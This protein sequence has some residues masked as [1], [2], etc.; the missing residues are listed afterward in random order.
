M[1]MRKVLLRLSLLLILLS[2]KSQATVFYVQ[3]HN[4]GLFP[5]PQFS[6]SLRECITL[7]NT[8]TPAAPDIIIDTVT[9]SSSITLVAQLPNITTSVIINGGS[10][11]NSI[12]TV[13][14][15]NAFAFNIFNIGSISGIAS[16]QYVELNRLR[17][18]NGFTVT[19]G[20]GINVQNCTLTLNNCEVVNNGNFNGLG[21]GIYAGDAI[22]TINNSTIANNTINNGAGGGL[23]FGGS[24]GSFSMLN[25]TVFGNAALSGS[26][27]GIDFNSSAPISVVSSTIVQNSAVDGGGIFINQ[28]EIMLEN[29]I[30]ANNTI[31]NTGNGADIFKSTG[32]DVMNGVNSAFGHN[33]IGNLSGFSFNPSAITAT[34]VSPT[35]VAEIVSSTLSTTNSITSYLMPTA[36]SPAI[37]AGVS[38]NPPSTDLDQRGNSVVNTRDIGAVEYPALIVADQTSC[39]PAVFTLTVSGGTSVT[40]PIYNWYNCESCST[41][42]GTGSTFVTPTISSPDSFYVAEVSACSNPKRYKVRTTVFPIPPTPTISA[43]GYAAGTDTIV[44][45]NNGPTVT[46]TSSSVSTGLYSWNTTPAQTTQSIVESAGGNYTVTITDVNNCTKASEPFTIISVAPPITPVIT[47]SIGGTGT[48]ICASDTAVLTATTSST[49]ITHYEWTINPASANVNGA[50]TLVSIDAVDEGDYTVIVYSGPACFSQSLPFTINHNPLPPKPSVI[51]GG[52]ITFCNGDS[53]VLTSSDIINTNTWNTIPVSIPVS[54]ISITVKDSGY[55]YTTVTDGN[56]CKNY[57]DTVKVTVNFPIKPT[58]TYPTTDSTTFCDGDSITITSSPSASYLWSNGA[59][60]QT[61]VVKVTTANLSVTTTDVNGCSATSDSLQITVIPITT[62]IITALGATTF[63]DGGSVTIESDQLVGN[64]WSPN[65]ETTTSISV[66]QSGSYYVTIPGCSDTSNVITVTVNPNPVTPVVTNNSS[67]TFCDGDSVLLV[68][69]SPESGLSYLWTAPTSNTNDTLIVKTSGT[70]TVTVSNAFSCSATSLPATVTVNSL[71]TKPIATLLSPSNVIC[72][73]DSVLITSNLATNNHWNNNDT[74]QVITVKTTGLYFLQTSDLNGCFSENSD[75]IFVTVNTP[76]KPV[77]T[78]DDTLTFCDGDSVHLSSSIPTNILWSNGQTTQTITIFASG[79]FYVE[80]TDPLNSCVGRSNDTIVTVLPTTQPVV[81]ALGN[82]VFCQGDSVTLSSSS[83]AGNQWYLNGNPITGEVNQTITVTASG[84]YS[85]SIPGCASQ[86][87]AVPVT[88][89]S[90]PTAPVILPLGPTTYCADKSVTL[91]SSYPNPGNVWSTSETTQSIVVTGKNTI[92]LTYT[93]A[94]GCSSTSLP[95]STDTIALPAK[96]TIT[97]STGLDVFCTGG[98]IDLTSSYASNNVWNNGNTNQTI[99]TNISGTFTVTHTDV[100]GCSSTSL[101]KVINE[102]APFTPTITLS[103]NDTICEGQ[104]LTLTS[105]EP[106]GNEW[107]TGDTTQSI[108]ISTPGNYNVLL[109]SCDLPSDSVKVTVL[110]LP[111]KPLVTALGATLF[112]QGDSSLLFSNIDGVSWSVGSV[113]GDSIY[114]KTTGDYYAINSNSFG[115][116]N[117]SDTI[118]VLVTDT[119][120]VVLNTP[121]SQCG[122]TLTFDAGYPGST[123][124]WS[125][126]ATTQQVTVNVG[127]PLSVTVTNACGS[128]TSNTIIV[129]INEVPV[130]ALGADIQQCGGTVNLDAQNPGATYF[131]S[132]NETTQSITINTTGVYSVT[133]TTAAGCSASD[134][135]SVNVDGTLPVVN[136]GNNVSQCGGTV[137]LSAANPFS[138]YQWYTTSAPSTILSTN[139]SFVVSNSGNYVAAVTNGCGT[140][141][142]TVSIAINAIPV[143]NLATSTNVCNTLATLNAQNTGSTYLWSTGETTQSITVAASGNYCVTVTTAQGCTASDCSNV[144]VS[145]IAPFVNLG[146]DG[147]YCADSLLLDAGNNGSVYTWILPNNSILNSQTIYANVSGTYV[148]L[149]NNGCGTDIDSITVNLL[150]PAQVDLGGPFETCATPVNL[151]A[152]AQPIGT[153]FSWTYNNNPIVNN[154]NSTTASV[155]GNYQVTV[156]N[157]LGCT[158]SSTAIVTIN[159]LPVAPSLT[160]PANNCGDFTINLGSYPVGTTVSWFDGTNTLVATGTSYTINASGTYYVTVANQCDTVT[161][162]SISINILPTPTTNL[163]GPQNTCNT[164][165]TLDAGVQ[166]AGS[167]FTWS[168]G[169]IVYNDSTGQTFVA[170]QT[171]A[172]TVVVTNLAGCSATSTSNVTIDLPIVPSAIAAPD[173]TCG[174]LT[175]TAGVYPV[176]TNFQWLLNGSPIAGETNSSITTNTNGQYSVIVSNSC[177]GDTTNLVNVVILQGVIVDLGGSQNTC[178]TPVTLNAGTQLAGSTF[179]WT[180]NGNSLPN[181]TQTLVAAISGVYAVTVTNTAGCSATSVSNVT[182]DSPITVSPINAPSINCGPTIVNAGNY[183]TSTHYQWFNNGVALANDTLASLTV[184]NSGNYSVYVFNNCG[185]DTTNTIAI[186]ILPVVT[187]DLGNDTTTCLQPVTIDAGAQSAGSTFVWF[188]NGQ[189]INNATQQTFTVTSSGNYSVVVTNLAGCSNTSDITVHIDSLPG[190]ININDPAPVCALATLDAGSYPIGTTFV[191][192]SL[193]TNTV[194]GN[195][196]TIDITQTDS[197]QV[198][199][200]NSCGSVTSNIIHITII[201]APIVDLGNDTTQCINPI[202][203]DAGIQS[204]GSTFVWSNSNGVISGANAQTILA[205]TTD[206]YTVTITN[207]AGC[208]TSSTILVTIDNVP[209]TPVITSAD[210]ACASTLISANAYPTGT[211]YQWFTVQNGTITGGTQ[212]NYTATETGSYFLT[213]TNSCGQTTS[214]TLNVVILNAPLV[215]LGNDTTTCQSAV[216]LDAG[217]QSSGSTFAWTQNGNPTGTNTASITVTVS[218][219]YG[220]TVTNSAGCSTTDLINVTIDNLPVANNIADPAPT[221]DSVIVESGVYPTGTSYTWISSTNNVLGNSSSVTLHTS[222]SIRLIVT[223][224]CGSDTTNYVNVTILSIPTATITGNDTSCIVAT[225]LSSGNPANSTFKWYNGN[226]IVSTNPDYSATTTGTYSLVVTNLAGCSDS[227]SIAVVID[228]IPTAPILDDTLIVCGTTTLDAGSYPIGTSYAWIDSVNTVIG[229]TQTLSVSVSQTV[230]VVI[231]NSCG[232]DT[233]NAEFVQVLPVPVVDLAGPYVSC[234]VSVPLNAGVQTAGSTYTWYFGN[235]IITGENTS[236][237]NASETGT[238]SLVVT[239][240]AGCSDSSSTLVTIDTIPLAPDLTAPT[241]N[242]G[243]YTLDAGL[244]ATGT[245][246]QWYDANGP[247]VN[248]TNQLFTVSTTGDY[249]VVVSNSCGTA[250]S[251]T[252]SITILPG[253]VVDLGNDTASCQQS[254]TLDAGVQSIGST[255]TWFRNNSLLV[256]QTTQTIVASQS[257]LYKVVIT[258]LAGCSDS[259][260]VLVSIDSLPVAQTIPSPINS[261]GSVILDAGN[262]T[263]GSTIT[264][265]D[266][267]NIQVGLGQFLTLN[268]SNIVHA[269]ISNVCGSDTTNSV[270]VNIIDT[271][272]VNIG[273]PFTACVSSG[274]SL[275]AGSQLTGSSISWYKNTQLITTALNSQ[276]LQLTDVGSYSVTVVVTNANGCSATSTAQVTIDSLLSVPTLTAPVASCGI[277][278]LTISQVGAGTTI[279]WYSNNIALGTNATQSFTSTGNVYVVLSNNC[280]TDTSNTVAVVVDSLPIVNIG[281]PFNQ[282]GG[283]TLSAGTQ[284]SGST[285]EWTNLAGVVLGNSATL[286]VSSTDTVILK[287]TSPNATCVASDTTIVN[288]AIG[289][290]VATLQSSINSCG[291]VILAAGNPG[292]TYQWYNGITAISGATLSTYTANASGLYSVIVTNA[293]GIDTSNVS[294]LTVN[295][296]VNAPVIIANGPTIF[297]SGN[298]VTLAVDNP[299]SGVTYTWFPGGLVQQTITINSAGSYY[300]TAQNAQGCSATSALQQVEVGLPTV[301]TITAGSSLTFCEGDSVILTSSSPANNLWSNGD[302][303]QSIIVYNPGTYTV[304]VTNVYN[305]TASASVNVNVNPAPLALIT[306]NVPTNVCIG[307]T[308][309]LYSAH[310]G[311]NVWSAPGAL[312]GATTDSISYFN[313]TGT[314]SFSVT[315]T[316]ASTGCKATSPTYTFN[317]IPRL[318]KPTITA[319]SLGGKC[320]GTLV[321]TSSATTGNTWFNGQTSSSIT[322]NT[323]DTVW[324]QV[325]APNGCITRSDETIYQAN[326]GT[327]MSLSLTQFY[328]ADSIFNTTDANSMDGWI[329]LTVNGGVPNYTYTWSRDTNTVGTTYVRDNSFNA[330]T[331]DLANLDGGYYFV[332]V[333]DQF[334][335]TVKDSIEVKEPKLKFKVPDG[336]SPNGDERNEVYIIGSIEKYPDNHVDIYNRWGSKVF[337][338]DGYNNSDKVWKGQNNSGNDLPEGTYYVVIKV[339]SVD[340]TIEHYCDLKR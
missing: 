13:K 148:A 115:C 300:V 280:S 192:T 170:T 150:T 98:S 28:N 181:T 189:T 233:S 247:I 112:C 243:D 281:G 220:V 137:S 160:A 334:G 187:V 284:A 235:T 265:Y 328:D 114:A 21:G 59:T 45:C 66:T 55:Y 298:D 62:P 147:N 31:S 22:L 11:T 127:G 77:I 196:Q 90:L 261:C 177:G 252:V 251:D 193:S 8:G 326:S 302:I 287:V 308:I 1:N 129:P 131:W 79:T 184:N 141:Y 42:I 230:R 221:C 100:N 47:S 26:G 175:I 57:S 16:T 30:V 197:V 65:S 249:H 70:Y 158:A 339:N 67:L 209:T 122:G 288:T 132:T 166:T 296:S 117:Y 180:L 43:L 61:I 332:T 52:P 306:S 278:N 340:V 256:S 215:N 301:P 144:Q 236:S 338:I 18:Q 72:Q 319:S 4:D 178:V 36:C 80:A 106:F 174:P 146:S 153:A 225:Q 289:A 245:S 176:G 163:G 7:A 162:N 74:T 161:S 331:E 188:K 336:I 85:V 104:S 165:V 222:D 19:L 324:V 297:C 307:D 190:S 126:G 113:V 120:I 312:N 214:D 71:P 38:A 311:G 303:A 103:G 6:G 15:F 279:Q 223:N 295:P 173:T 50:D 123:Y 83:L 267:A 276:T 283:V 111:T 40:A 213:V 82:T 228:T 10:S 273:G 63:C 262:Y 151:T 29:S 164:P 211:T 293:C 48:A 282:C 242:C 167:T 198:T 269:V 102:V 138:T 139:Q 179:Q 285:F 327:S 17:I 35:N 291:P 244:Y 250:T 333:T 305:C 32:L 101:P 116:L 210:T 23:Y 54:A 294:T 263:S 39:G 133:V 87:L 329:D 254:V 191:W 124:L 27:G 12:L 88:V 202:L 199:V 136:L 194:I 240:L 56:L 81:S 142:D 159:Q 33:I 58:I 322:L 149:V 321:L 208:S 155:S 258:N 206:N 37:D 186:T 183:P 309:K 315:V 68:A 41:V 314:V 313:T 219:T 264:W 53:V 318:P 96:P 46:L 140:V 239:N 73:G 99:T 271:P 143:V 118:N 105:S 107:S 95:L 25:S 268:T 75:T 266:N 78:A 86:S 94:N 224:S 171:G 44:L 69:T 125:N 337:S 157:S 226:T 259:S 169:N 145:T 241:V 5:S 51:V 119:P 34:N 253:I 227:T 200:T 292:S 2:F 92:S 168:Q 89:N 172:Y 237:L 317:Y 277:S 130:V 110:A 91:I 154:T 270:N 134:N 290:P 286:F 234:I 14:A 195:S 246:Y 24:L 310:V 212:Q 182:I 229:T 97:T 232:A 272:T 93:D 257:G 9:T 335:C 330:I 248:E 231:Y 320:D 203:L 121:A 84:N 64:T 156:T 260:S 238:Y 299:Q 255:F 76:A 323:V 60:T 201:P 109:Q 304:V 20:G 325:T 216:T 135:I 152:N 108:T 316:E 274:V 49:P 218:G 217:L 275:D 128:F 185:G 3:H 204:P 205:T 207:T